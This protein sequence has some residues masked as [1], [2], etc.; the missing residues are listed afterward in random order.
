MVRIICIRYEDKY[1]ISEIFESLDIEE[2]VSHFFSIDGEF[3][4][5]RV[6]FPDLSERVWKS[7]SLE[8]FIDDEEK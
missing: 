5:R 4:E 1:I 7:Y 3:D 6:I 2:I 8:E